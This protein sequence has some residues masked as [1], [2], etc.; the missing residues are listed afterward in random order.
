VPDNQYFVKKQLIDLHYLF[1]S[2][3]LNFGAKVF[4]KGLKV[5]DVLRVK[6]KM[7]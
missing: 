6:A 5:K 4:G 2:I 1:S 3:K 7:R